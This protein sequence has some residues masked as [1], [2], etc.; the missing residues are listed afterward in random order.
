MFTVLTITA[1]KLSVLCLY[2]RIFQVSYRFRVGWMILLF[3]T[4][5][6][7]LATFIM[8][9]FRCI[10]IEAAW[11]PLILDAKCFNLQLAFLVCETINCVTD[12]AIVC[13]PAGMIRSLQLPLR[14]KIG[15]S[16]V[17]VLGGL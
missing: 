5:A 15:L 6:W 2:Y 16:F 11:N 8:A 12:L 1:A 4:V 3:A 14:L 9:I 7:F 13:L 10:P 17:F